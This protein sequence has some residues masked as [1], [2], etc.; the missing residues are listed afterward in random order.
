MRIETVLGKITILKTILLF[1]QNLTNNLSILPTDVHYTE[2]YM[3]RFQ[4]L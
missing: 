1:C 3:N 4:N 2:L